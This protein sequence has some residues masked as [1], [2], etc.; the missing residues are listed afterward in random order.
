VPARSGGG[1]TGGRRTGSPQ[2]LSEPVRLVPPAS[3]SIHVAGF[4]GFDAPPS[5]PAANPGNAPSA[6]AQPTSAADLASIDYEPMTRSWNSARTASTTR[7]VTGVSTGGSW[8][9]A[10]SPL[11]HLGLAAL[12]WWLTDGGASASTTTVAAGLG[13][14]ALLWIVLGAIADYRRLGALG[15]EYRPSVAWIVAGLLFYLV[16][17]AVHVHR[18]TR[19]GTAPTWVYVILAVVVGAALGAA[20]VLMPRNAGLNELRGVETAIT[21]EMQQQGLE[22]SVLCPSE[23][24]AAIGSSFVCTAYDEVGAV[25]LIRVTWTGFGGAFSYALEST[26]ALGS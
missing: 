7:L 1:A 13:A 2:S 6:F 21:T 15:H 22:Y 20:S 24:S 19:T 3:G 10:L 25:A 16:V 11:F 26:A 23:A 12:G 14:V 8:M 5:A 17:R 9:L 4:P 18:T